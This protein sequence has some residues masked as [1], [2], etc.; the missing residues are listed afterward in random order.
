MQGFIESS[1][2]EAGAGAE[3][4][5]EVERLTADAQAVFVVLLAIARDAAV[6]RPGDRTPCGRRRFASMTMWRL[7][8]D[9]ARG[10]VGRGDGAA[11]STISSSLAAFE[12]RSAR[13]SRLPERM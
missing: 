7:V 9:G 10:R 8:L 5:Q 12:G 3:D 11:A 1:K 13:W 4:A 2:F 6:S